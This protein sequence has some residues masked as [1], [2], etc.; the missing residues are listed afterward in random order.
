MKGIV[1]WYDIRKGFG[2]IQGE[3]G[4]HIFVHKTAIPF[5]DIFLMPGESVEYTIGTSERGLKAVDLKKL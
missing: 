3:D 1:K 4:S 5:F 2:F